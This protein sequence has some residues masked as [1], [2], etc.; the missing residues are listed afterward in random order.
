MSKNEIK[1]VAAAGEHDDHAK[2]FYVECGGCNKQCLIE[3][4][5]IVCCPRCDPEL[6]RKNELARGRA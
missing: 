5:E 3:K 1:I 6:W 4:G 2:W